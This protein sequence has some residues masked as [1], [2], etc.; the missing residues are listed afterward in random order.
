MSM[1]LANLFVGTEVTLHGKTFKVTGYASREDSNTASLRLELLKE[2]DRGT[3]AAET[4]EMRY[5]YPCYLGP[6]CDEDE[7]LDPGEGHRLLNLGEKIKEGDEITW[8]QYKEPTYWEKIGKH[9]ISLYPIVELDDQ[10][11]RRKLKD[12]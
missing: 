8:D 12:A 10:P 5:P 11:C 4:S 6:T 1:D 2:P 3:A 7:L 9:T